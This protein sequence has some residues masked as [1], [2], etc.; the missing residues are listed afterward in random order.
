[1]PKKKKKHLNGWL[2]KLLP[3]FQINIFFICI[4][5]SLL[6]IY[7]ITSR[8]ADDFCL[9]VLK[10]IIEKGNTTTFEWRTGEPPEVVEVTTPLIP[11][12]VDSGS[13]ETPDDQVC[14]S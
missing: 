2:L 12:D 4:Q 13:N 6:Y 10:Y 14:Y 8:D 9:P 11:L 3:Y 7:Y 1:M 5:F